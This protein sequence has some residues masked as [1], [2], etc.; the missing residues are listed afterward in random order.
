MPPGVSR[1]MKKRR[2]AL[3]MMPSS[4]AAAAALE[5]HVPYTSLSPSS[6]T[7][8]WAECFFSWFLP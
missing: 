7:P 5:A 3:A 1:R 8:L 6:V 4:F 2:V